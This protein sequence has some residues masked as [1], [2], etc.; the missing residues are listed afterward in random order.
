MRKI[1]NKKLTDR[2]ITQDKL[3]E[4]FDYHEDGYLLWRIRAANNVKPCRIAGSM[5]VAGYRRITIDGQ[6]FKAHRLI[7]L[8]HFG[9]LPK[10]L[11]H[12][13][14]NRQNN[15]IE[16]LRPCTYEQ[17]SANTA[18]KATSKSPHKNVYK[19]TN[20]KFRVAFNRKRCDYRQ[21]FEYEN[22]AVQAA[23]LVRNLLDGEFANHG[24]HR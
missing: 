2:K 3:K 6:D 15:R 23:T 13:D 5:N 24:T 21:D 9:T 4:L 8:W 14:N 7:Y 12:I 11:D 10:M 1:K 16:N 22:F 20:G 17:N 19:L 18:H